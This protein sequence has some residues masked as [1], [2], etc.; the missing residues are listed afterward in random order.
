MDVSHVFADDDEDYYTGPPLDPPSVRR[1]EQALGVRFPDDYIRL[2][3]HR[4]GGTL[5]HQCLPTDFPTS[6]APDHIGVAAVLGIGGRRGIDAALGGS[7]YMIAE[8]DYP[9]I[10][11]V[12]ADMTGGG[13]DALMLDY[14]DVA[15]GGEPC[16][17]YIGEDRIPVRVADDFADFLSRLVDCSRFDDDEDD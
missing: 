6:W 1:A 2:L 9:E 11:V 12:F 14:R 16:V 10:G 8:W 15:A 4:N 17:A 5:R 13:Y 3:E 7:R